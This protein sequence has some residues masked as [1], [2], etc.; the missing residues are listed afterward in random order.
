MKDSMRHWPVKLGAARWADP[1][2]DESRMVERAKTSAMA[3]R[4]KRFKMVTPLVAIVALAFLICADPSGAQG[5]AF[6]V[7]D[8]WVPGVDEV[9]GDVPLLMTIR[10]LT[11]ASDALMR[12][13]CPI[14]NFAEKH[15]V[16]RGEGAPAMRPIASIPIAAS[17]TIILRANEYHVMLLQIRQPLQVGER[18]KCSVVF[19]RAGTMETEVE[20]RRSP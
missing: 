19:Q 9:G 1:A 2:A 5:E 7:T 12:V 11:N 10:N 20:V 3:A 18:F 17:S 14:A 6:T 16:D 13:R 8:A 15:I 4:P